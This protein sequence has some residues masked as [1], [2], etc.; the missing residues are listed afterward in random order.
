[1]QTEEF[2]DIA[3]E[4]GQKKQPKRV[5]HFSDGIL[6][7]YS[8]EE[9]ENDAPDLPKQ[10]VDT[11]RLTWLPYFWYYISN[12]PSNTLKV[13]DYLGENLAYFFGITSPKYQYAIDEYNDSV[14]QAKEDK[15]RAERE[16]E[17]AGRWAA[18]SQ[19]EMEMQV[20]IGSQ[21]LP[22]AQTH[23]PQEQPLVLNPAQLK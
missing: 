12:T 13:C 5:L 20:T 7:E 18:E 22:Q 2:S 16:K 19:N 23:Q 14:A 17:A 8:D 10:T 1:M 4:L 15:E 3:L 9:D 11:S 6:E 21:P